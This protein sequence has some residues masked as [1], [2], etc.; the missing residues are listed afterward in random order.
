MVLTASEQ[1]QAV[2]IDFTNWK[3]E[4]RVRKVLP[5]RLAFCATLW[6]PEA[7]WMVFAI[8][9]EDGSKGER[10]FPLA[11]IHSWQAKRGDDD[12]RRSHQA[13]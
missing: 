6:H 9:L 12:V 11:N 13:V 2:L 3:G 8:D 4:R 7:Q 5:Q 1:P 10:G